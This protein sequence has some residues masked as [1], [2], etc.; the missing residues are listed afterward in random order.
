MN[1]QLLFSRTLLRF[2]LPR[3]CLQPSLLFYE[4]LLLFLLLAQ[5]LLTFLLFRLAKGLLGPKHWMNQ[6]RLFLRSLLRVTR[7]DADC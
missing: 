5:G 1:P 6:Q 4:T 3:L 2:S 7:R